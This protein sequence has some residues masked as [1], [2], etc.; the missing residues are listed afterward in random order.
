MSV[1]SA[2]LPQM[3]R[4]DAEAALESVCQLN[5]AAAPALKSMESSMQAALQAADALQKRH[6]R[7]STRPRLWQRLLGR[8]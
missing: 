2:A 3:C 8:A 6:K 4:L 7:A 5:A 1:S